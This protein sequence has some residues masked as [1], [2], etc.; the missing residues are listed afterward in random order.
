MNNNYSKEQRGKDSDMNK[1]K[2]T[3]KGN[4]KYDEN[5]SKWWMIFGFSRSDSTSSSSSSS[6][7]SDTNRVTH[8]S[9]SSSSD[10]SSSEN[11]TRTLSKIKT[12]SNFNES[13]FS[14]L[15]K[16]HKIC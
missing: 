13:F 12:G 4:L 1:K 3:K 7:D 14:K 10:S 15:Y 6:S 2:Q 11:D 5:I 16:F 8:R 9:S